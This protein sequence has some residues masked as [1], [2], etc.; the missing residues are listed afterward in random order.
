M[1]S[2][3]SKEKVD[4]EKEERKAEINMNIGRERDR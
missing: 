1:E 2:R 3:M 4:Q